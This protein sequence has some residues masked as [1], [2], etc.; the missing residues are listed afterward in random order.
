MFRALVYFCT[1][2]LFVSGGSFMK[3]I[4]LLDG[5]NTRV[6]ARKAKHKYDP[7]YIEKMAH[8]C[9]AEDETILRILYYDCAPYNGTVKLPVSGAEKIFDGSDRWLHELAKKDLFA[10][11]LGVLK[12]RG[13][14]PRKIP[15]KSADLTDDDFSPAFEQKGVDMRIGLDIALYSANKLADR[16]ILASQDTDCVPAMKLARRSG[17]QVVL[18]RF[19]TSSVPP[20]LAEHADFVRNVALPD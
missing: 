5:G 8:A 16:I 13:F 11:R 17:L 4:V 20:E 15:V 14:Q 19:G 18:V 3:S 9:L 1:G 2:A 6:I 12:F 10:I 7:N